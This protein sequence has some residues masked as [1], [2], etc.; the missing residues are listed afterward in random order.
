MYRKRGD[1]LITNS[2]EIIKLLKQNGWILIA[3][4]GS[5]HHFKHATLKGKI[6]VPHPRKDLP[7]KTAKNI[8]TMAGLI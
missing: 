1:K 6:T 4:K 8:L 2:T 7:L 3:T 5:H